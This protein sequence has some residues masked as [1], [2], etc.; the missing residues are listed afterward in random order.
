MD[1][2]TVAGSGT[3]DS[4]PS[5]IVTGNT[6]DIVAEG[7][8]GS[9]DFYWATIGTAT[10]HSE[11]VAGQNS[12]YSATTPA[13]VLNAGGVD[14]VAALDTDD[15]LAIYWQADGSSTWDTGTIAGPDTGF[16]APAMVVSGGGVDV[17]AAGPNGSL[18]DY[19]ALNGSATFSVGMVAPPGSVNQL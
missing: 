11:V 4:V 5:M 9:L 3:T 2:Q 8:G 12:A 10:W 1:S 13:M 15:G 16:S 7:P 19:Y 14:I 6:I 18:Y 17:T